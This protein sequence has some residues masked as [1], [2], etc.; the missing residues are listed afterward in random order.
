MPQSMS[1]CKVNP[2]ARR[3]ACGEKDSAR[4]WVQE[5]CRVGI[6]K[7][8]SESAVVARRSRVVSDAVQGRDSGN[9]FTDRGFWARRR[10]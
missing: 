1:F 10:A 6:A 8:R 3:F 2:R 4:G 9:L 5:L 7:L